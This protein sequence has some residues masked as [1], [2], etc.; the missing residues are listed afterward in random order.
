MTRKSRTRNS[1]RVM[2]Q[3][4]SGLHTSRSQPR[5]ASSTSGRSRPSGSKRRLRTLRTSRDQL[6]LCAPNAL[7]ARGV[8]GSRA[9]SREVP[10]RK[11]AY[12]SS[13][14]EPLMIV[15]D[16]TTFARARSS[17]QAAA[18]LA[19]GIAGA[20]GSPLAKPAASSVMRSSSSACSPVAEPRGLRQT[21]GAPGRPRF[22]RRDQ[23]ACR[24]FGEKVGRFSS[25]ELLEEPVPAV[26]VA[27]PGLPTVVELVLD[28]SGQT[29]ERDR[30]GG[31]RA[32]R[33]ERGR[34]R[35][36]RGPER[37]GGFAG[38]RAGRRSHR[39]ARA[40]RS[41]STSRAIHLAIAC[42]NEAELE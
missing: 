1:S 39:A 40:S 8:A 33:S 13:I 30:A 7:S 29:P 34:P 36:R 23:V 5:C 28:L 35:R 27:E 3:R 37:T 6:W 41:C 20:R 16:E 17:S 12:V 14:S 24:E 31:R 22:A 25:C 11:A 15:N 38:D 32:P 19:Y 42:D 18:S 9:S 4:R 21:G 26:R 10:G 2:C